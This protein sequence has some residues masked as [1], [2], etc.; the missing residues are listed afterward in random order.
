M[1][2]RLCNGGAFLGNCLG[3]LEIGVMVATL[4]L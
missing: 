2:P 1:T 4:P 3:V